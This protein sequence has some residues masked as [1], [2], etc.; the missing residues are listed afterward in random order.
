MLDFPIHPDSEIFRWGP[1]ACRYFY[2]ADYVYAVTTGYSKEY[3]DNFWP[4]G[5][6]LFHVNK[7][8]WMQDFAELRNIGG[9]VFKKYIS[10]KNYETQK[11]SYRA[12]LAKLYTQEK[13]IEQQNLPK[14]S[15]DELCL[16]LEETN[17][18]IADLWLP[19]LPAE[20]GN[21]GSI[22]ILQKEL[23]RFI[24][25]TKVVEEVTRALT[26]SERLSFYQKEEI[27]LQEAD[28]LHEH[29]QKYFWLRNSYAGA[30]YLTEDFFRERKSA[31]EGSLRRAHKDRAKKIRTEKRSAI[32][33]YGL[34]ESSVAMADRIV[35]AMEWQDE[36]KKEIWIL[37]HCKQRLLDEAKR[38]IDR[39][40]LDRFGL[41]ELPEVIKGRDLERLES[42]GFILENGRIVEIDEET[43]ENYWEVYTKE[44]VRGPATVRGI[45]A[46]NGYAAGRV[47]IIRDPR[48][49]G[50]TFEDGDILVAPMTSPDYV[51]LIK[52]S[53]AVV[54][55]AGG[56][57]S[58]AAITSRELGKPCIVG[59]KIATQLL[60]NGDIVEVDA[61]NGVVRIL[62]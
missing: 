10:T 61:D 47:K 41:W 49:K 31:L 1:L 29:Q 28:N 21:Y 19:T 62:K 45:V 5:I 22:E 20:I 8:V 14:L 24:D 48:D 26:T 16:L 37:Q 18:A 51:F 13:K 40:N 25:D 17:R 58:H 50:I 56:L 44:K 11:Q 3:M 27:E 12:A 9:R 53:S 38:R 59:T 6:V 57:T 39:D 43:A 55:D 52:K 30:E 23:S 35:D 36:R 60:R 33:D 2:I 15:S 46:H 7:L 54:T 34:S 4:K 32:E 42:F